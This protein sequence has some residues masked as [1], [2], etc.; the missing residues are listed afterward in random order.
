MASLMSDELNIYYW[1][2]IAVLRDF[3]MSKLK[4]VYL[5]NYEFFSVR[6]KEAANFSACYFET[7]FLYFKFI[8]I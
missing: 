2:F 1:I 3:F 4:N 5:L 6:I 8:L 7:N